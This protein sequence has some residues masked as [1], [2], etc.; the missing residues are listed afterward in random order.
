M[1]G[2]PHCLG[3][4]ILSFLLNELKAME[5][6]SG[7][8]TVVQLFNRFWPFLG[9]M[10]TEWILDSFSYEDAAPDHHQQHSKCL[11][12]FHRGGEWCH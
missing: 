7:K 3:P 8:P 9:D 4:E 6:F 12:L 1:E 10:D 2:I 11:R 5:A